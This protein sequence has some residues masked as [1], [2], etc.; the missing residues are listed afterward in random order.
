MQ[1]PKF[2]LAAVI[3]EPYDPAR[4][5][6]PGTYLV[7]FMYS[8]GTDGFTMAARE[9]EAGKDLKALH[10]DGSVPIVAIAAAPAPCLDFV[11]PNRGEK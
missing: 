4:T 9:T 6:K 10:G 7:T 5:Y 8:T 3:W 1:T 2:K 11:Q